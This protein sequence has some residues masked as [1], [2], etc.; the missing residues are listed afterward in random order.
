ME[1]IVID[2]IAED[3]ERFA[4]RVSVIDNTDRTVHVVS[5]SRDDYELFGL[6][7]ESPREICGALLRVLVGAP[8]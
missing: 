1:E 6:L 2:R 7:S 3:D 4:F 8:A 5:L